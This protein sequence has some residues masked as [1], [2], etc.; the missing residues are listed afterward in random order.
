MGIIKIKI[1]EQNLEIECKDGEEVVL[2]KA[3]DL[4][5][6]K[7]E[8]NAHLK[9]LRE[10][11]KFLMISLTLAVELIQDKLNKKTSINLKDINDELVI[12]EKLVK[13]KFDDR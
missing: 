3:S 9:D 2:K 6:K 5:N 8:D 12:L 10:S 7:I 11:K 13:D 1:E 4:L